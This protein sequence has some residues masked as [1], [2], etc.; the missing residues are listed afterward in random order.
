MSYSV[1]QTNPL[2]SILPTFVTNLLYSIFLRTSFFTTLLNLAK[3]LG[4]GVNFG[5]SNLSTSV[6]KLARFGFGAKL[7]TSTCVTFLDQFLLHNC[8]NLILI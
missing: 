4:T 7:L 6:L 1:Y 8:S 2:V 5:R 3:S